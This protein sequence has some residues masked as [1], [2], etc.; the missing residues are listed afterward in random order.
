MG[1]LWSLVASLFARLRGGQVPP[2]GYYWSHSPDYG[3]HLDAIPLDHELAVVGL[4][5]DRAQHVQLSEKLRQQRRKA[6]YEAGSVSFEEVAPV[7]GH[8]R[9][10][11]RAD[12]QAQWQARLPLINELHYRGVLH[13]IYLGDEPRSYGISAQDLDQVNRYV[14]GLGY[15]TMVVDVPGYYRDW[16]PNYTYY[17]LTAYKLRS[18]GSWSVDWTEI[19][20]K[21]RVAK[22]NTVVA[23]AWNI[24]GFPIPDPAP[25]VQ[26]A[27]RL[28]AKVLLWFVWPAFQGNVV[29]AGNTPDAAAAVRRACRRPATWTTNV[30]RR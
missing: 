20:Y 3:Y 7:G 13:S 19:E 24:R 8:R 29:T 23:Q 17:G 18:D 16:R 9:A 15:H 26:V 30:A 2:S 12:W 4:H 21:S 10:R 25:A 22:A 5:A 1:R 6:I 11:L 27:Q 14:Q 28:R